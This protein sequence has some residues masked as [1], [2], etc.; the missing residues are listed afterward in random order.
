[1][2][3]RA[4]VESLIR[5]RRP[6]TV[7]LC[8]AY[9]SLREALAPVL[10][11]R[12]RVTTVSHVADLVPV[13]AAATPDLLILDVDGQQA[14]YASLRR[15][16]H[17]HGGLRVLLL[18]GAFTLD[19]QLAAVQLT[20]VSF[21]EKVFSLERFREKVE[22]MIHGFSRSPIHTRILRIPLI[23][24]RPLHT[25][26]P[27][28]TESRVVALHPGAPGS[29]AGTQGPGSCAHPTLSPAPAWISRRG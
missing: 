14:P 27:K 15:I 22:T 6:P 25:A 19:E 1:M 18:A 21:L 16:R 17:T 29:V 11:D 7:V 4:G 5:S 26:S 3:A 12:Y 10:G 28:A 23:E 8:E 9:D 20:R 13:L 2:Q 24:P